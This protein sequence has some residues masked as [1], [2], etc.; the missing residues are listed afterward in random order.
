MRHV[1]ALICPPLALLACHRTK[2]AVVSL[3]LF[4]VAIATARWGV[5][6]FLDIVLVLW[7]MRVVGSEIADREVQAFIKTVKPIPVIHS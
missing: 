4:F 3:V 7:A 6:V 1:L 5:G 2:Q